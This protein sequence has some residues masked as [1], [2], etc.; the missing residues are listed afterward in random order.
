MFRDGRPEIHVS[1]PLHLYLKH[2]SLPR[3]EGYGLVAGLDLNSD[4]VNMAVIDG[5]A[6]IVAMRTA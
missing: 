3:R 5:N 1:I 4:R 6:R 2:F